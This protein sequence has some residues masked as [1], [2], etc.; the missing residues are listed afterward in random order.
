MRVE[1]LVCALAGATLLVVGS[2]ADTANNSFASVSG[3]GVVADG[4]SGFCIE[5]VEGSVNVTVGERPGWKCEKGTPFSYD[6]NE[7]DVDYFKFYGLD[8]EE[9]VTIAISNIWVCVHDTT[10]NEEH[11]SAPGAVIPDS[12]HK[13][14]AYF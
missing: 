14:G 4:E 8:D 2:Y 12:V 13:L 6:H 7:G 9:S 3:D 1:R 11:V 5:N 10:N